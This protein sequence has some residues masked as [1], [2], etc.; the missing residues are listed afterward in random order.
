MLAFRKQTDR[1]D[2]RMHRQR[3]LP[4]SPTNQQQNRETIRKPEGTA[5][6]RKE[7]RTNGSNDRS[8]LHAN[9][10]IRRQL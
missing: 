8:I 3:N 10:T 2:R 4:D 7:V 5:I 1:R 6:I 9:S